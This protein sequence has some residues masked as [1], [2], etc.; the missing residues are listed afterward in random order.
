MPFSPHWCL[1]FA[2]FI[3]F[4]NLVG[5]NKTDSTKYYHDILI[6][7]ARESDVQSANQFVER[8]IK[9]YLNEGNIIEATYNMHVIAVNQLNM[10]AYFE[11]E[12]TVVEAMSLLDRLPESTDKNFN[13]LYVYSDLS[14]V[15]RSLEDIAN[16]IH[17]NDLALAVAPRKKDSLKIINNKGNLL[18]DKK[19]Y[20]EAIPHYRHAYNMTLEFSDSTAIGRTM[21]NLGF[22]MAM[23]GD[24]AGIKL[25]QDAL[26]MRIAVSHLSGIYSSY[27]Q[28][29]EYYAT[30]EDDKTAM[31]YALKA[32]ETA[33]KINSP[34]FIENALS[35]LLKIGKDSIAEQFIRVR[36]SLDK[37]RQ[38]QRNKYAAI[39]YDVGK[40]R[41]KAN[42]IN[43]LREK[44]KRRNVSIQFIL[45]LI[46]G[47]GIGFYLV[48]RAKHKKR[49]V[50]NILNTEA[51]ISQKVHDEVANDVYQ[52]MSKLQL[53]DFDDE[54]ILDDLEAIYKKTRDISR[55]TSEII[56]KDDFTEQLS[57]L[58]GAFRSPTVN[59]IIRNISNISWNR[60]SRIKKINIYRVIQELL[61]NMQK[62]S[63]AT[64]VVISFSQNSKILT[65]EYSDNG[66]GSYLKNKNGLQNTGNRI[67]AISGS[68]TFD[69]IPNKGFRATIKV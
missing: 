46:A 15:Y 57:D 22:A 52:L 5:Q 11:A 27:Q 9:K 43:L 34:S 54:H 38:L 47:C 35:N 45:V 36:D 64:A 63:K 53:T 12:K 17:Y 4:S 16:A 50:E 33:K 40:E 69:S 68:F 25:M 66:V 19:D 23:S 1:F 67:N 62:H 2:L 39:Q 31:D 48:Q 10:G 14:R 61:V 51:R 7:S 59:I 30:L 8:E 21:S 42:R 20:S 28:L 58:I 13:L 26:E 6:N 37:A 55:E 3:Q 49:V 41:E 56:I 44:E 65:I 24:K 29:A 60:F 18:V 32:L